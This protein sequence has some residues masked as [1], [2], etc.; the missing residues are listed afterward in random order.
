[1][2]CSSWSLSPR[3]RPPTL[4]ITVWL[5]RGAAT[6][7][8]GCIRD[9]YSYICVYIAL[10]LLL[11][12]ALLNSFLSIDRKTTRNK[13]DLG[14]HACTIPV[15]N[16]SYSFHARVHGDLA[17]HPASFPI[18]MWLSVG[19]RQQQIDTLLIRQTRQFIVR[20]AREG[21]YLIAS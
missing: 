18:R 15:R 5:R 21:L 1:M 3:P 8:V 13:E 17:L 7:F 20:S 2:R 11:Y 10:L 4:P 12:Q 16:S 14:L 9:Q 6:A 19:G